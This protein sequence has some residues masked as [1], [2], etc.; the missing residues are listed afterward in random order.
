MAEGNWAATLKHKDSYV[1][2][3]R[4]GAK[5]RWRSWQDGA[6]QILRPVLRLADGTYVMGLQ[7]SG[8][9]A[10]YQTT[11]LMMADERWVE[12]DS[13]RVLDRASQSSSFGYT[14]PDLSRVDEIG[15]TTLSRG[16]GHGAGVA[17]HLDWIEVYGV[18]VSRSVK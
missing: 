8:T 18:P 16:G 3:S 10:D 11:D 13:D 2:L 17:V 15:F 7:G 14:K 1:D 4:P 9:T 5:I 12:F 6:V